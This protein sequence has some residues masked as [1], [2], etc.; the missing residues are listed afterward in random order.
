MSHMVFNRMRT[1]R[2]SAFSLVEMLVVIGI[3]AVVISIVLPAINAARDNARTATAAS[4]LDAIG[5]GLEMFHA[6]FGRYPNSEFRQDPL[7][8]SGTGDPQIDDTPP[9]HFRDLSGAHWLAR[10][11]SGFDLQGVVADG[12]SMRELPS[13][14]PDAPR[15][16]VG[17]VRPLER[18]SRYVDTEQVA[19]DTDKDVFPGATWDEGNQE[20]FKFHATG[21]FVMYDQG[22]RSP[23]LYYRANTKAPLPFCYSGNGNAAPPASGD[24]PGIYRQNDNARIAGTTM[25]FFGADSDVSDTWG[26]DFTGSGVEHAKRAFSLNNGQD[27]FLA[28]NQNPSD[29]QY[30]DTWTAYFRNPD[31]PPSGGWVVPHNA[32]TYI[33]WTAGADGVFGTD[34]DVKNF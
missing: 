24:R 1:A 31:A 13:D 20:N 18:K 12:S 3:I 30:A 4:F 28:F 22:F 17:E 8:W 5:K 19:R 11:M 25:E 29:S 34:D 2:R 26:W 7:D 10:A 16:P 9:R 32:D 14:H 21:R 6:D 15:T 27:D 23:V 33:L